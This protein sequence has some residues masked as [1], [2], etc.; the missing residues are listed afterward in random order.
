M[1]MYNIS[2]FSV[3]ERLISC[4]VVVL[5]I[6]LIRYCFERKLHNMVFKNIIVISMERIL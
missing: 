3:V 2:Y 4:L 1:L 5:K 6:I